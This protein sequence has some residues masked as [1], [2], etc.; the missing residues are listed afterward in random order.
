[1][2]AADDSRSLVRRLWREHARAEFP[3]GLTGEELAGVDLVML[4]ADIAGCVTTW[5]DSSGRLD[6]GRAAL[7]RACLRDVSRVVPL[8]DMADELSYFSRLRELARMVL[9]R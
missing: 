6:D 7:L 2:G 4:D 5:L 8:L 9:H 1:M 3:E